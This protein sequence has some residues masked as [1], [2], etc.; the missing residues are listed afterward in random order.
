[1][2]FTQT[3][4]RE[5]LSVMD[6]MQILHE[7]KDSRDDHYAARRTRMSAA[8]LYGYGDRSR[9]ED[10]FGGDG[11]TDEAIL[12]HLESLDRCVSEKVIRSQENVHRCVA[13]AESLGMFDT[14]NRAFDRECRDDDV[15]A[16]EER[17]TDLH[18]PIELLWEH[19]YEV[20][21]GKSKE[22]SMSK[23]NSMIEKPRSHDRLDGPTIDDGS[24]FR[25]A[26]RNPMSIK[27]SIR[28]DVPAADPRKVVDIEELIRDWT[29][30]AEQARA[31]RIISGHS[32]ED[33]PKPLRMFLSGQ[34]GTGKSRVINAL[35]A[36]FSERKEPR[37][38]RL[39][40]Y[41][42]VA[43]RNI[44]GM[45]LHAALLL[46]QRNKS[47]N[48]SK[49][50]H[51]LVSMWQGV[52]YLFVDEVSMVSSKMLTKVSSALCVAKEST[53]AFGGINIILLVILPSCL[54]WVTV[55][56]SVEYRRH[57][58]QR[59]LYSMSRKTIVAIRR[60]DNR[61][62]GSYEAGGFRELTF[63]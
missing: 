7:C 31:F 32:M 28:Q 26:F 45:T 21:R 23:D 33:N 53:A 56:F 11:D 59:R 60:Y 14:G 41:T 6:N 20:R 47:G 37:R 40:S 43:A 18:S 25:E 52:D 39:A 44:S 17:V 54:L 36:Y 4:S 15:V 30:N 42:G 9:A 10:D 5:V 35:R 38:F 12:Q 29:L 27:P 50:N 62:D 16:E 63:Y 55:S 24:V 22:N 2:E 48:H 57:L 46:N 58:L 3:A 19:E 49:S 1:M 13:E 51:D 8:S 34:G 61:V